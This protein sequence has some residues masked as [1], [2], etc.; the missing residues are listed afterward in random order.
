LP[1]FIERVVLISRTDR[2]SEEKPLPESGSA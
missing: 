2:G 1:F